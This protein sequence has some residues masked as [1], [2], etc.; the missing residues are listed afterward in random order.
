MFDEDEDDLRSR[1][2]RRSSIAPTSR[3]VPLCMLEVMTIK[4]TIIRHAAK[5][6]AIAKDFL[7][8]DDDDDDGNSSSS[9]DVVVVLVDD[10][11]D[12]TEDVQEE[13]VE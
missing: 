8:G 7:D 3:T 10:D 12:V 6:T 9:V 11:E 13:D 4:T 1:N 5:R 2:R